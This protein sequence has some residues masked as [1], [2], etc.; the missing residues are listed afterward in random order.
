MVN[1]ITSVIRHNFLR[2]KINMIYIQWLSS[3]R[4]VNIFRPDYKK[5][6]S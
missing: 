1:M 6:I 4:S 2:T 5:Q 3:Y